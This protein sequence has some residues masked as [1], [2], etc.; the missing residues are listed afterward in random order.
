[1][2]VILI[3][4]RPSEELTR[5]D[6]T[7]LRSIQ[8]ALGEVTLQDEPPTNWL[9]P[10]LRKLLRC[11][12]AAAYRP[13]PDAQ[14]HWRLAEP[15]EEMDRG[16]R[17]LDLYASMLPQTP[18]VFPY[19]PL[20]PECAQRNR[21]LLLR[22]IHVHG[23]E[24]TCLIEEI[25]PKVGLGG[26]D[27]IRALLCDGPSLL[28]WIGGLRPEPFTQREKRLFSALVPA[29]RRALVLHRRLSDA[30]IAR[31]GLAAALEALGV[32]A[33][34]TSATG[35][36]QHANAAAA[37]WLDQSRASIQ[38]LLRDA[39]AGRDVG[40]LVARLAVP[41]LP[42]HFLV[43][44]RGTNAVVAARHG[45][46]VTLWG[47]TVREAQVLRWLAEGDANKE[48]S[49]KLGCSEVSVER[50]VTSLMRKAR[51]DGW[52]R[53]IMRFWTMRTD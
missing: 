10:E 29:A 6:R 53:L 36:V 38:N 1:M 23:P 49:V 43:L 15:A 16:D 41:G 47:A 26:H 13:W 24:E 9:V 28:A 2:Y 45:V 34:V 11:R 32:S 42:A 20:R 52:A 30:S 22:E 35:R 51:C 5:R 37:M 7:H 31:A 39:A 3:A 8:D 21:V 19:D 50:H 44:L 40:A 18:R 33:F 12:G 46:A 14:G 4:V 48:I 17:L 27:Q 25:W